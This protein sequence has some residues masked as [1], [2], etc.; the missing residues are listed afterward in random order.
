MDRRAYITKALESITT[1][2]KA[3]WSVGAGL[4]FL[5]WRMDYTML[6]ATTDI[7]SSAHCAHIFKWS[8]R[9]MQVIEKDQKLL[10]KKSPL[11]K[12][13]QIPLIQKNLARNEIWQYITE[14]FAASSLPTL[15]KT[16]GPYI[17]WQESK[18]SLTIESGSGAKWLRQFMAETA[19][20]YGVKDRK[21]PKQSTRWAIKYLEKIYKDIK[22][23]TWFQAVLKH[24]ASSAEQQSSL[25][26]EVLPLITIN[27]YNSGEGHM[28][29]AL[30][31]L[32]ER[33]NELAASTKKAWWPWGVFERITKE[34]ANRYAELQEKPPYYYHESS[35]Y[36]YQIV[37]W[38]LL[39]TKNFTHHETVTLE[40][41][42]IKEIAWLLWASFLWWFSYKHLSKSPLTQNPLSRRAFLRWSLGWLWVYALSRSG[43]GE[44]LNTLFASGEQIMT[45]EELVA[46][47]TAELE[48]IKTI[49]FDRVDQNIYDKENKDI[50]HKDVA[51]MITTEYYLMDQHIADIALEL[52]Q[53]SQ[54]SRLGQESLA[55][56]QKK[57]Y[58][59]IAYTFYHKAL[60]LSERQL[61]KTW[62]YKLPPGGREEVQ[63]RIDYCKNALDTIVVY[64]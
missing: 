63:E 11:A 47:Y 37:H 54:E 61:Q 46:S 40:H 42:Y 27:A 10:E 39:H 1:P 49:Y 15:L 20:T 3:R 64:Q 58:L 16:L 43:I 21:D 24:F 19:T 52:A 5:L 18:G 35:A 32:A 57:K 41:S 14:A 45:N 29:R 38:Y 53:N 59:T 48:T 8:E 44:A 12:S 25:I 60:T 7:W 23:S 13:A 9:G 55:T 22:T 30:E 51:Y 34:Y 6:E 33:P 17:V 26:D 56:A 28:L 2:N 62:W 50:L 4:I 31:K 36:V